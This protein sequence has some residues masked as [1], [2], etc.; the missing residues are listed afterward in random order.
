MLYATFDTSRHKIVEYMVWMKYPFLNSAETDAQNTL[1]FSW[2]R[3]LWRQQK[4]CPFSMK[5]RT[6]M[7]TTFHVE[8]GDRVISTDQP[9][10]CMFNVVISGVYIISRYDYSRLYCHPNTQNFDKS[11]I[12]LLKDPKIIQVSCP[13]N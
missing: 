1:F 11:S 3:S 2:F 13:R 10:T 9:S 7:V 5:F 8:L 12:F 4:I 6:D